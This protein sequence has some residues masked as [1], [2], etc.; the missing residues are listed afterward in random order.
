MDM[1]TDG[2]A[3][4]MP[5]PRFSDLLTEFLPFDRSSLENAIDR[6]LDRFEGLGAGLTDLRE[7][8]N[9]VPAVA[10]TALTALAAE[11][12][13]RRLRARDQAKGAPAEDS[14]EELARFAGFP[15]LW[16]LGEA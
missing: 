13:L 11:V 3:V 12:A 6:F 7:P 5:L 16:N 2:G 8:T 10:A 14:E 4:K 15:N 1:E 9:L